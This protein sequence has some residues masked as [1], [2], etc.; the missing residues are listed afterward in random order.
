[1]GAP[2]EDLETYNAGWWTSIDQGAIKIALKEALLSDDASL[3][4]KAI[5]GR[6]LVEDKFSIAA[7]ARDMESLYD[8]LANN[9]EQP[10]FVNSYE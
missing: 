3:D 5:Q 7:V 9:N 2:W 8:W 1:Q 4:E 10:L 6:K